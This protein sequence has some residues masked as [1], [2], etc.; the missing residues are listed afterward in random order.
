[1][2]HTEV[3]SRDF[4]PSFIVGGILLIAGPVKRGATVPLWDHMKVQ[5]SMLW[6]CIKNC[7]M[8]NIKTIRLGEIE[9]SGCDVFKNAK[10]SSIILDHNSKYNNFKVFVTSI[11]SIMNTVFSSCCFLYRLLLPCKYSYVL[12]QVCVVCLEKTS[13]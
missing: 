3:L 11:L 10:I 4:K 5:S 6:F 2:K 13:G 1:M 7:N 12:A 8:K 9:Y